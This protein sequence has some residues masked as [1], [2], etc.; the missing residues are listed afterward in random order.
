MP[1]ARREEWIAKYAPH[2]DVVI[3]HPRLVE[4][5][6]DLFDKN[7]R[8]NRA[9]A[10]MGRKVTA[11]QALEGTFSSEGLVAMASEDANV[12][13]ALARSLVQRMDEGNA[14]RLWS[15]VV[16]ARHVNEPLSGGKP[17]S[18]ESAEAD[19]G[20]WLDAIRPAVEMSPCRH[21]RRRPVL[22]TCQSDNCLKPDGESGQ[23]W[24]F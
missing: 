5:G 9:L 16:N 17:D 14:R 7:G 2:L 23:P 11:A 4:T 12:E 24:L 6:L 22:A 21:R 8:H 13:I 19:L 15:K 18:P 1:L 3:S 10:L 20:F